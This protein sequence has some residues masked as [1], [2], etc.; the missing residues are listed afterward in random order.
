MSKWFETDKGYKRKQCSFYLKEEVYTR[1]EKIS[2]ENQLS[3]SQ[4]GERLMV[5]GYGGMI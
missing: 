2:K 4:T 5:K 1:L 3:L